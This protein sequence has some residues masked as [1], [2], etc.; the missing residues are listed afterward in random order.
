MGIFSGCLLASDIDGTL[1]EKNI[2]PEQNLKKIDYFIA[3]GGVFTIATGR[4]IK[5]SLDLYKLSHANAPLIANQ[6]GAIYDF[7][8]NRYLFQKFLSPEAKSD[9]RLLRQA[10][11]DIGIEIMSGNKNYSLQINQISVWHAEY[12]STKLTPPPANYEQFEWE[13]V[14]IMPATLNEF[15]RLE[16][17]CKRFTSCCFQISYRQDEFTFYE[18]ISPEVNK[19]LALQML[20]KLT[21]AKQSFGIGDFYN[22]KE[23]IQLADVGAA[24]A[25]APEEIKKYAKY[26]TC[27]CC[28]GAV[29]DFIEQIEIHL[30]GR[31]T[32]TKQN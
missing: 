14:L 3:N 24:V 31:N 6:G 11:P 15:E 5:T 29:A 23:L 19:G 28:D 26:V 16:N 10:F 21:G 27:P 13:K 12:Q 4:M 22:D 1:L 32:W 18:M 8:S 30:K 20:K 25:E 7:N 17:F 9:L 2:V